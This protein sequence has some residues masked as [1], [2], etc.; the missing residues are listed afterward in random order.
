MNY[1]FHVTIGPFSV[2]VCTPLQ[3]VRMIAGCNELRVLQ[4]N[5]PLSNEQIQRPE[6]SFCLDKGSFLY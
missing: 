6:S 2:A 5:N 3:K 1:F 4:Y